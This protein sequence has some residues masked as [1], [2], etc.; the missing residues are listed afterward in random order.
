MGTEEFTVDQQQV[1]GDD[2]RLDGEF[3]RTL[4]ATEGHEQAHLV[5]VVHNHPASCYRT[6]RVVNSVD[7]DVL[8]LELPDSVVD[9]LNR[10]VASGGANEATQDE[11]VAALT[12][13]TDSGAVGID[14]FDSTFYRRLA[15]AAISQRASPTT[16]YR[17]ASAIK[18]V[19]Q[20]AETVE[21]TGETD[22]LD[23]AGDYDVTRATPA[24]E[25]ARD[26][27]SHVDRSRSLL[28]AVEPP[29]AVRLLD[30]ARERTMAAKIDS[31]R[32]D[33]TVVAVVG[34]AHL[35]PLVKKIGRS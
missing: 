33:R 6:R 18:R 19:T 5:G 15:A 28:G 25:Q 34:M 11:M 31:L 21:R 24:T 29:P 30:E 35:E 1:S 26:E 3:W 20:E 32:A 13:V 22:V 14:S 27:R 8:A 9:R 4:P 12:A 7:P 17:T 16:L 2:P 23:G 10:D